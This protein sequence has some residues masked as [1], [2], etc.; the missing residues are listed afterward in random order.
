MEGIN[1]YVPDARDAHW[2]AKQSQLKIL[3]VTS[4]NPP[5]LPLP[6]LLNEGKVLCGGVS[7]I[8]AKQAITDP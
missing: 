7:K 2:E 6:S 4:E 1:N 3:N 5:S 8:E